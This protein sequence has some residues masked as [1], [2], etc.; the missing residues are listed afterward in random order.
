[1]QKVLK[2]FVLLT[3]LV[4]PIAL[5]A[6]RIVYSE[7]EKDDSRRTNFDIIGKIGGNVLVFKNN[8]STNSI[9]VY[10]PDMK[11]LDRVNLDFMPD[12]YTDTYFIPFP[13]FCYMFYEYQHKNI[14]HLTMVKFD[15][16]GKRLG[17]PVDL[18]TT[19]F[20]GS[21]SN[22]IY[23]TI[24][25]EDKQKI[26]IFKI[27]SKDPKNFLF[28][29]FLYN[30]QL[31]LIDRHHLGLAMED[32]NDYFTDFALDNDGNLV[33]AK[34]LKSNGNDYI[35]KVYFVT[36]GAMADSFSVRDAG[37]SNHILDEIK[38]RVDNLNK[39]YILTG[40][41]YRQRKGNIEGLYT[42][43]WDRETDAKVKESLVVFND[44]LRS[45]AKSSEDNL[46]MAFNDFFI[47][48]VIPK[49]DGGFILLSE[50]EY[51]TSRGGYFNRWDYMYG[52]PFYSPMDYYGPSYYYNPYR[53]GGANPYGYGN[54]VRYHA[55]NIMM[56]SFDKNINLEWSNIIPKSQYDDESDNVISYQIMNTGG[57]LHFLYNEYDRRNILLTD[58]S[59]SPDGKITRH[60]TLRNLDKGYEF[61]PRY[62]K[63]I[64]ASQ[65]VF[66][67]IYRNYLCFAKAEF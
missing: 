3:V 28:T 46:K 20:G 60:P 16:N 35:S 43:V 57:E 37:T 32:R 25:S 36:K 61:M 41:Y 23:T 4:V 39:Q 34:F 18:D 55:E 48:Q 11:L 8:R 19:H 45:L 40:F 31:E 33:F 53:Y 51:T 58:Q 38:I 17:E 6:Q 13:D 42:V 47:K 30:S 10:N 52:S 44:D 49:K 56:L 50:A 64:G 12:K 54:P 22:K 67:C 9:C 24:F 27:N 65:I 59:I 14:I 63:Q 21:S 26:I 1:M 62:G 7:P 15:G 5:T 29:T 2:V 66:P